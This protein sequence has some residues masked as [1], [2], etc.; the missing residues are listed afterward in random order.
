MSSI[1]VNVKDITGQRFGR[2]TVIKPTNERHKKG[3]VIW[4]CKCDCGKEK[5]VISTSLRR[6]FTT[7]CGCY[8][9]EVNGKNTNLNLYRS[10][11]MRFGTNIERISRDDSNLMKNNTSGHTGVRY[12]KT[13]KEWVARCRFQGVEIAK[14]FSSKDEA[15]E[16]RQ[17]MKNERDK[18]VEWYSSL[19]DEEKQDACKN[20]DDNKLYFKLLY[21]QKMN[22][23]F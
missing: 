8:M 11:N 7:S 16:C 4:L 13:R 9:K 2:L 5:K 10:E 20:Y 14:W 1:G 18:F 23:I 12:H 19:T 15:I 17:L 21:K 3:E 22:E 6:G